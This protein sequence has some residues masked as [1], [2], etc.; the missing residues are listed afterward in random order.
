MHAVGQSASCI[1]TSAAIVVTSSS[2]GGYRRHLAANILNS[3]CVC[4]SVIYGALQRT[5]RR[6]TQMLASSF[7][8]GVTEINFFGSGNESVNA[9]LILRHWKNQSFM[10]YLMASK[11]AMNTCIKYYVSACHYSLQ[12]QPET[13]RRLKR[14][15]LQWW[16]TV[17][18]SFWQSHQTD[19]WIQFWHSVGYRSALRQ[20][21]FNQ[22]TG[23]VWNFLLQ[24]HRRG[25]QLAAKHYGMRTPIR[26]PFFNESLSCMVALPLAFLSFQTFRSTAT[27][28]S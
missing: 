23:Q 7:M 24:G 12:H 6:I 20:Y 5:H 14:V 11:A 19:A 22:R 27:R 8:P 28:C 18:H 3:P 26:N 16:I 1:C 9:A 25:G 13:Y 10:S 2:F 17:D 15:E 4:Y 21:A